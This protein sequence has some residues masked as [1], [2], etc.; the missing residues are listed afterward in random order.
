MIYNVQSMLMSFK[1]QESIC[2]SYVIDITLILPSNRIYSLYLTSFKFQEGAS[3]VGV[4]LT[5]IHIL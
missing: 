4:I 2:E 1:I 5:V 3:C